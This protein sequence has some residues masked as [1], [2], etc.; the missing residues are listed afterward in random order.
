MADDKPFEATQ[1]RLD[2]ARQEGDAPR[3]S[4]IT[5]AVA[6]AGGLVG[7]AGIA[8]LLGGAARIAIVTAAREQPIEA[9]PL[10]AVIACALGPIAGGI[11][12]SLL[13]TI[14]QTRG[15]TVRAPRLAFGKLNPLEGLKRMFSRDSAIGAAKAS[16]A[17]TVATAA[18]IPA[19]HDIFALNESSEAIIALV[20]RA[21][22]AVAMTSVSI[23]LAFGL[24]DLLVEQRKWR[25]RLR[26]SLDELKRDMKQNE[27]D[28]LLRSRR[29]QAH[30]SLVRGS[31][32]RLREAAFVVTNPTHIAIALEYHP[33]DV[34][35][36]KVLIRSID[37]GAEIVKRRARELG[38]PLVENVVLARL[39]LA[40]ADVG[41]YIPRE[42]YVAVAQIVAALMRA[43]A[44]A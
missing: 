11:A 39:L 2:R 1:S 19:L 4:E 38:V 12:G 20:V 9:A 32:A 43:R 23:G 31:I 24:L 14:V 26:M 13:A 35:V 8:P 29:K 22:E 36:P 34:E 40:T 7:L 41:A 21:L 5:A 17:A 3:S 42:S 33:P 28:P 15:I 25:H 27:G 44:I 10:L 30:R 37:E 18:M 6:F 16:V